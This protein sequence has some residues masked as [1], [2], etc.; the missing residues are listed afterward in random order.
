MLRVIENLVYQSGIIEF[1]LEDSTPEGV[2]LIGLK[3]GNNAVVRK[4]LEIGE[5]L[6]ND[7]LA[8]LMT[9]AMPLATRF[10]EAMLNHLSESGIK[11]VNE[12]LLQGKLQATENHLSDVRGWLNDAMAVILKPQKSE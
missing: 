5:A 6:E 2:Y 11:T 10:K 7:Q 3:P 12:N 9:M 8:P 1:W 4:K